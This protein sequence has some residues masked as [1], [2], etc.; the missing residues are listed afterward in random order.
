MWLINIP[1]MWAAEPSSAATI[2]H[3]VILAAKWAVAGGQQ[4]GGKWDEDLVLVGQD[5]YGI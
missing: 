3:K 4:W 1:D 5:A 2:A